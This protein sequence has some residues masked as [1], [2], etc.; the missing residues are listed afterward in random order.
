MWADTYICAE[1]GLLELFFNEILNA[2]RYRLEILT[3]FVQMLY[4]DELQEGHFQQDGTRA[5]TTR[6]TMNY[7]G[8]CFQDLISMIYRVSCILMGHR[9]R[10]IPCI[11]WKNDLTMECSSKS[12]DMAG[13]LGCIQ[14]KRNFIV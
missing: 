3:P 10:L 8:E 9:A 11:Q 1:E 14:L 5:H 6:K 2:E 13:L 7:A 4:D 12:R